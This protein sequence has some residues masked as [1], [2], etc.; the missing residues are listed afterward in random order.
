MICSRHHRW[1]TIAFLLLVLPVAACNDATRPAAELPGGSPDEDDPPIPARLVLGPPV[2]NP[3]SVTTSLS[4]DLPEASR[5]HLWVAD[6]DGLVVRDLVD[7]QLPAGTHAYHWDGRDGSGA[8]APAGVYIAR[9]TAAGAV[10]SRWM[11][12][13]R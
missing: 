9:L 10:A 8:R 6:S 5:V 1:L 2:P 3:F 4:I 12:L 13:A 11:T 7:A